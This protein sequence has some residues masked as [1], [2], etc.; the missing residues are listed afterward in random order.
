MDK[1]S[2]HPYQKARGRAPD[3]ICGPAAAG[4]R[5]AGPCA[6]SSARR[7]LMSRPACVR[8]LSFVSW[9]CGRGGCPGRCIRFYPLRRRR[10]CVSGLRFRAVCVGRGRRSRRV[11]PYLAR[12]R[13]QCKRDAMPVHCKCSEWHASSCSDASSGTMQCSECA[14]VGKHT[15]QMRVMLHCESVQPGLLPAQADSAQYYR[16]IAL[17]TT[18]KPPKT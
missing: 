18:R 13:V 1:V 2:V 11:P 10:R 6:A 14:A 16:S 7:R 12:S 17:V 3:T 8:V 9:P 4:S 15:Q 5:R